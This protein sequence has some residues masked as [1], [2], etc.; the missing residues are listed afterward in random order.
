MKPYYILY[1]TFSNNT[2]LEDTRIEGYHQVRDYT[3]N[4]DDL[5]NIL[6]LPTYGLMGNDKSSI[7]Q[8]AE[9]G[10]WIRVECKDTIIP[11]HEANTL[12]QNYK[13][14]QQRTE[15]I[16]QELQE[17]QWKAIE[18]LKKHPHASYE[19]IRKAIE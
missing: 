6:I 19:E 12:Y 3:T 16:I 8:D 13:D 4:D 10:V 14:E 2:L 17:R 18:Y 9:G 7:H 11:I 5:K 15:T 1:K